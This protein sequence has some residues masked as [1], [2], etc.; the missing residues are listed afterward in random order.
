MSPVELTDDEWDAQYDHLL[1]TFT[2]LF[3]QQ[4]PSL[5][6][7]LK[8]LITEHPTSA[9]AEAL[10]TALI[11]LSK[12]TPK[13][14]DKPVE[15]TAT[16]LPSFKQVEI[17]FGGSPYPFNTVFQIRFLDL[18]KT[19]LQGLQ[20]QDPTAPRRNLLVDDNPVLTSAL[21]GGSSVKYGLVTDLGRTGDSFVAEGLLLEKPES[22]KK[23]SVAEVKAL[24]A[25]IFLAVTGK[26]F[27]SK[28]GSHSVGKVYG[29]QA[30]VAALKENVSGLA[31]NDQAK[32][33]V[34]VR[35]IAFEF[36]E[37]NLMVIDYRSSL[38]MVK[39]DSRNSIDRR[40]YGKRCLDN[41][42]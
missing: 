35:I 19:V 40:K 34:E 15:A 23:G 18:F 27:V 11:G 21:L 1:S 38:R 41:G 42:N 29:P 6:S 30:I 3:T 33:L 17:D 20:F 32:Q 39:L 8:D 10:A 12:S 31:L 9:C 24:G 13:S 36:D 16:A 26:G 22:T 14:I 28:F 2:E 25:A 7:E 37:E 4:T 5:S